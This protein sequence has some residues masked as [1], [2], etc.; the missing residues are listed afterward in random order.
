MRQRAH[1]ISFEWLNGALAVA[2]LHATESRNYGFQI[3]A[4]S[5]SIG[6]ILKSTHNL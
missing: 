2:W 1:C 3:E 5:E 4:A 6:H